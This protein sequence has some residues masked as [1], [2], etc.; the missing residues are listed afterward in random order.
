MAC[1]R[2]SINDNFF[3]SNVNLVR[4]HIA[5]YFQHN[6][7]SSGLNEASLAR[8]PKI[9]LKIVIRGRGDMFS[10]DHNLFPR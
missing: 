4:G 2:V 5:C 8:K 3:L 10:S 7:D 1:M 9:D 6:R